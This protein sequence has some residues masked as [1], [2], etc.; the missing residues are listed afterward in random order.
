[1]DPLDPVATLN[2]LTQLTRLRSTGATLAREWSVG[3][4][5]TCVENNLLSGAQIQD[6]STMLGHFDS[7]P[8]TLL[9]SSPRGNSFFMQN[10]TGWPMALCG[11]AGVRRQT[12]RVCQWRIQKVHS[13]LDTSP[14][15]VRK[16]IDHRTAGCFCFSLTDGARAL[17]EAQL[18]NLQAGSARC[19]NFRKWI[20]RR[21]S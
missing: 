11:F 5:E 10:G 14:G 3:E 7:Q 6:T 18:L 8:S 16:G 1:M 17:E 9:R 2:P 4:E 19:F 13:N 21:T 15:A 20:R 12:A